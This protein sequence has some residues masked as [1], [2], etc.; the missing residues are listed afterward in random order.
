MLRAGVGWH[1]SLTIGFA[2]GPKLLW[3]ERLFLGDVRAELCPKK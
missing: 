3:D 1:L 2:F